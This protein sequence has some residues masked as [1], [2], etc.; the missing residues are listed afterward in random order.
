MG[1]AALVSIVVILLTGCGGS[2]P[3]DYYPPYTEYPT[4]PSS[5]Y[6]QYSAPQP[7]SQDLAVETGDQ[8]IEFHEAGKYKEA[9]EAYSKSLALHAE[10]AHIWA[11]RGRVNHNL[12]NYDA[13][14]SDYG[15]AIRRDPTRVYAYRN[16][17]LA[18]YDKENYSSAIADLEK[19]VALDG[20]DNVSRK[21]VEFAKGFYNLHLGR[22]SQAHR[23]FNAVI[24][25]APNEYDA[26]FGRG[27][28]SWRL[29]N[30]AS[31][32][33]DLSNAID[34]NPKLTPA[35]LQRG[36][37][38]RS[39]KR[40]REALTDYDKVLLQDPHN[41]A[42]LIGRGSS[43]HS[44][45]NLEGAISDLKTAVELDNDNADALFYAGTAYTDKQEFQKAIALLEKAKRLTN[46]PHVSLAHGRALFF[47]GRYAEAASNFNEG[48]KEDISDDLTLLH[49]VWLYLARSYN[50]ERG[51][52]ELAYHN[53]RTHYDGWPM[54]V[55]DLFLN[56]IAPEDLLSSARQGDQLQQ[57]E[58]L[59]EAHYYLG[60]FYR[61]QGLES[62][63]ARSFRDAVKTQVFSY[64]E[65]WAAKAELAR[66]G[67]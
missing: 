19:A 3:A 50:G 7:S 39:Q 35:R 13:A 17:G 38:Y 66:M 52:D 49:T 23:N 11:N 5:A 1:R 64:I 12:G 34:I 26:Y 30:T 53:E 24:T 60:Q 65:Y 31:A 51:L 25:S 20:T 44:V 58:R 6:P 18:Y 46:A 47:A 40:Y 37:L 33:D 63:A 22:Y 9:L 2:E 15:D 45:G 56:K 16:R 43:R 36:E 4:S 28:A 55:V 42:A 54:P 10:Q 67:Y 29:G 27:T 59:C 32:I 14:F 8:G 62:Y 41:L 48:L 57:R 21:Y 61:I